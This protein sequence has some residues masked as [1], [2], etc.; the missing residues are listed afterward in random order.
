MSGRKENGWTVPWMHNQEWGEMVHSV[1]DRCRKLGAKRQEALGLVREITDS[2]NELEEPLDSLCQKTCP[3]CEEVCCVRATVWYDRYD[4]I[5]SYL[6][7]NSFPHR[8]IVRNDV[9]VCCH[10]GP[11]GCRLS[12][13]H[14]PFICTW[15][16][17]SSQLKLVRHSK[18]ARLGEVQKT[19]E[20]IKTLR[21]KLW[22]ILKDRD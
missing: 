11:D 8:Q 17:C 18:G 13:G 3:N 20:R 10:L 12:R 5:Y 6:A 1:R 2:Y 16:L 15:Y 22:S 7:E 21:K 4:L 19:V 14:R 9:G